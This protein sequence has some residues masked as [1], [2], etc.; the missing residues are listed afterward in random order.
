M[1]A[2]SGRSAAPPETA[3]T[4]HIHIYAAASLA[5][6]MDA[7]RP[8]LESTVHRP[9][10]FT[11]ASSGT[12]ARQILQGAP[13]DLFISA[14][15]AWLDDVAAAGLL[16]P[17]P[18]G[19][20]AWVRN[21][22]VCVV[23]VDREWTPLGPTDLAGA[24]VHA[25][26]LATDTAPVGAYAREALAAAGVALP[27]RIVEGL[28]ARDTLMKV[29]LGAADAGIVYRTDVR[30]EPR[31]RV[32]FTFDPALHAPIVYPIAVLTRATDPAACAAAVE[33]L[34]GEAA[35]AVLTAHGF[36]PA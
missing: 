1:L 14:N 27:D 3:T 29:A 34:R 9:V 11:S 12:L 24:Q 2:C 19:G 35:R 31:V 21:R 16:A 6:L 36:E 23:P 15:R 33:Y 18:E 32:A 4:A 7:L 20:R 22:L 13:A 17:A 10:R 28:N 8:G 30:L 5:D 26:A 25:L